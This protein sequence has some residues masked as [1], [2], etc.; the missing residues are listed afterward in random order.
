[1]A[2][3]RRVL[4]RR[5][6]PLPFTTAVLKRTARKDGPSGKLECAC[7]ARDA[8]RPHG[9]RAPPR[10]FEHLTVGLE[11]RC[12]IQ[13]S[14]GGSRRPGHLAAPSVRGRA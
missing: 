3:G 6:A 11:G 1:M 7:R 13:L 10:R 12:S 5:E 4:C 9:E 8:P 14:Y 2:E